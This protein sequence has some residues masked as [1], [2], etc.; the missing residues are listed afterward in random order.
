MPELQ[1]APARVFDPNHVFYPEIVTYALTQMALS[2]TYTSAI[3][4]PFPKLIMNKGIVVHS[5]L[6]RPDALFSMMDPKVRNMSLTI[7][8]R[9]ASLTGESRSRAGPAYVVPPD[10][11]KVISQVC[12]GSAYERISDRVKRRYGSDPWLWPCELQY[13]RHVRNGCFHSNRFNLRASHK[14]PTAINSS[15]P[16]RWRTSILRDDTTVA[17]QL[18]LGNYLNSGDVPILLADIEEVLKH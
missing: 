7:Q 10:S 17:G 13:I 16:P 18:V 12:I 14:H 3:G 11:W 8:Y 1:L 6:M 5:V 4:E 9:E 15:N 2:T